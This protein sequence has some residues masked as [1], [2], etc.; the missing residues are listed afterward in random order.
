MGYKSVVLQTVDA[1][2]A[3][4]VVTPE[5]VVATASVVAPKV[6]VVELHEFDFVVK[7]ISECPPV[8][9]VD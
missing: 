8:Y 5:F 2:V 9:R 7:P 1:A 6:F 4:V 3:V